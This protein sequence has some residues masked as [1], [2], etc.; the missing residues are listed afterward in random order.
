MRGPGMWNMDLSLFRTFALNE[1]FKLEFKA[2]GFNITNTPKFANPGA[3]VAN[4]RLNTDGSIQTLNNFS[5]IT[6]T[7]TA[8][9]SPS[10]RKFRFGLRL[11]F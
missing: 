8:L 4:M 9:T 3:N 6:G 5:S 2:E 7:L 10:E 1:R 11:S